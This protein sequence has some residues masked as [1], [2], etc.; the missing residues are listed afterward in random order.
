MK[1]IKVYLQYPWKFPDSPYYKYLLKKLPKEIE[2]INIA[3]QKGTITNK[4][5]FLLSNFLKKNIR[6]YTKLF[7]PS[8]L[9]SHLSPKG[10]YDLIHCAH[11]LSKNK[12]KPWVV[13]FEAFWQLWVSTKETKRGLKKAENVLARENCKKILPWTKKMEKELIHA[14]PKLNDKIELVYPAVPSIKNLK[15]DYNKEI[16]LLFVGRYFYWKGG[17]HAL[18]SMDQLTKKYPNVKGII[19]SNVPE[20]IIN[21]YSKNKKLIFYSLIPQE[22]LFAV[23]KKSDILIY[24]GYTDSFGFAYLEAMSFGIPI[25]TVNGDSREELIKNGKEGIIIERPKNFDYKKLG[26][27]EMALI[28]KLISETSKLIENK[29]IRKEMSKNCIKEIES[30]RF[31]IKERNKKLKKIYG[32]ALK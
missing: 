28:N 27:N 24:P 8:M 16:T 23:Y 4:R 20:K 32:N 3:N 25:I 14:F 22:K 11:C 2:Y 21:K 18:E 7:Y 31:S 17:L 19:V 5:F 9:N 29:A 12:N 1:R 13:D 30:G 10:N 15:K 26:K 6:K